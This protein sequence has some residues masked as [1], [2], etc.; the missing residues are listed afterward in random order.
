VGGFGN[1]LYLDAGDGTYTRSPESERLSSAR[2]GLPGEARQPIIADFDN[3]GDQDV[4]ITYVGAAHRLLRNA[5]GGRLEDATA[6]AGLGDNG[7]VVG[8][9]TVFD[10]D[11]D[12]LLDVYVCNFGDYLD[13]GTRA[14]STLTR[15]GDNGIANRLFRNR[16]GLRFEEVAESGA[17]D[18]GW[19]RGVSHTDFDRDGH[20]DLVIANDAGR[21]RLLRNTGKGRFEDVSEELGMTRSDHSRSVGLGDLEADGFPDIYISNINMLTKDP[22]YVPTG[23]KADRKKRWH[24]IETSRLYVSVSGNRGL[25]GYQ[26]SEKIESGN[27]A[28]WAWDAEFFDFDN[29][30]DDDLYVTNGSNEYFNFLAREVDGSA[31]FDWNREP[32]VLYRNE[33]ERLG[34]V[35][36]QNG[37]DL[38]SNSRAAVYVDPDRDGDLDIAINGFHSPAVFL[39]NELPKN[40]GHWLKIRLEG[41]PER[42]SSR[43]AIGAVILAT[44]ADGNQIWRQVRGGSGHLSMEPKEQHLGLGS[45]SRVDLVIKRPGGGIQQLEGLEAD[46]TWSVREN[47]PPRAVEE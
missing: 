6:E 23:R 3:D 40:A 4:L 47:S 1:M 21:N 25:R 45:A 10:F 31:T 37:A 39:R 29:D 9:A 13:A 34:I 27:A 46:R 42:G 2:D 24:V 43:D 19:C 7:A 12:G 20:Q 5:G 41:D 16:G 38:A 36:A 44:T 11:R 17:A 28:G 22:R 8:A 30:G 18:R 14:T 32:N 33:G 15:S 26:I 35:P